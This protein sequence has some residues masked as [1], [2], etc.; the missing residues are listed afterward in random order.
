MNLKQKGFRIGKKQ[1]FDFFRNF[2][3]LIIIKSVKSHNKQGE[4]MKKVKIGIVGVGGMGQGHAESMKKVK[5]AQL[6]AVCD[7]EPDRAKQV[8][9][10]YGVE[11]FVDYKELITVVL[12]MQ[13]L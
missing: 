9:E 2:I 8:G 6:V 5:E 3:I 12:Q 13:L 7:I 4:N 10:K 1:L 11:W